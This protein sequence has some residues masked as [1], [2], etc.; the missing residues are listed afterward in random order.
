MIV[1]F[2][3]D[4]TLCDSIDHIVDSMQNAARAEGF[5]VP[6][7]EAVRDIIGLGLPEGVAILFPEGSEAERQAL[8][9][10]YSRFYVEGEPSGPVL[11]PGT[12]DLL[13]EL[14][15]RGF[16]LAIATGKSRRGLNRV[17]GALAMEEHFTA[18]RCADETR[19]KPHPLMLEEILLERG[20]APTQAVMIGDSE[21]DLAM[22]ANAGMPSI[23]ISHGVHDHARLSR[24][25]PAHIVDSLVELLSLD[26]LQA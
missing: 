14:Q 1:I 23:G 6:T 10:S 11:Y 26:L 13:G 22:A 4:G 7:R 5:P 15:G 9:A 19:S 25:N 12:H 16:E 8:A 17:L 21:H 3:W 18:T 20:K 2:D 24:H